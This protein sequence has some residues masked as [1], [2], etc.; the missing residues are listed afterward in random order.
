MG[1]PALTEEE[2]A[3]LGLST[4]AFACDECEERFPSKA[5]LAQHKRK[6]GPA[7]T[8]AKPAATPAPGDLVA[9]AVIGKAV[10]NLQVIG[11]YLSIVL[12]HT[13][14]AIAGVPGEQPDD[15]PVVQS[16][17]VLAGRVLEQWARRDER[18]LRALDRFNA[19][20]ETSEAI[21]LGASLGAA[22]A[23]DVG[24]VDPQL[25]IEVGPFQGERAIQPVR[26]VIGDVVD[27]VGAIRE[28]E[29]RQQA[30]QQRRPPPDG[31]APD[32]AEVV[33]GGME[34]T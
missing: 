34:G 3:A 12:P 1:E 17:A 32:G 28:E 2:A 9:E 11:G 18:V 31:R 27:Y 5:S 20:F 22:V 16:R 8:R 7:R 25:S 19:L 14:L 29:E 4:D 24:V 33:S 10:A 21:E 13:G 26:A 15:P 23:V 6:H 30:T